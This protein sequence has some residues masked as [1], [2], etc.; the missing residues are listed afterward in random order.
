[1]SLESVRPQIEQALFRGNK[2]EAI[3]VYREAAKTG[4]AEAKQAV[5]E[6][7]DQLR[8][9]HPERFPSRSAEGARF[10]R[11]VL[12][13]AALIALGYLLWKESGG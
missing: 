1:V 9:A 4:L 6:I 2:I 7:E 12:T 13:V 10:L 3:K 5:E 8:A 11:F